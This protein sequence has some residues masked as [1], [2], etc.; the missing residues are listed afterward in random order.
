MSDDSETELGGQI[1]RHNSILVST[2]HFLVQVTNQ[3]G[4]SAGTCTTVR[5]A[6]SAPP[7]HCK[8]H[9]GGASPAATFPAVLSKAVLSWLPLP[10]GAPRRD[11]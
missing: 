10:V 6:A 11:T 3:R 4:H 9:H 7:S 2:S 1:W 5:V 8:F